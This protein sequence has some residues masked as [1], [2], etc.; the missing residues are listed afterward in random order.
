MWCHYDAL[1]V[2]RAH[3]Q[4]LQEGASFGHGLIGLIDREHRA[5]DAAKFQ[6]QGESAGKRSRK[7]CRTYLYGPAVC[8]KPDVSDGG[9]GLALLYPARE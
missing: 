3:R 1:L 4:L 9:I 8:C 2:G 5:V 7:M 6:K